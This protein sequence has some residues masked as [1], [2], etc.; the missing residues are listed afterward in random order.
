MTQNEAGDV[1][2]LAAESQQILGQ[3]LRHIEFSAVHVIARLPKGNAE[4]LR[5]RTQTLPQLQCLRV[6]TSR[7][8]APSPLR[9]CSTAAEPQQNSSSCRWRSGFSGINNNWSNPF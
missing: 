2:A 7:S 9:V 5:G 4:E 3:A 6:G 8:E 1:I